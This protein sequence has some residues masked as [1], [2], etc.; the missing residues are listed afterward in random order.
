MTQ[1]PIRSVVVHRMSLAD[2]D[3]IEVYLAHPI[4][5]WLTTTEIGQW[6]TDNTQQE[7]VWH[8]SINSKNYSFDIAIVAA[9][10]EPAAVEFHLRFGVI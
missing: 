3:D 6:V 5:I 9:L 8:S 7:L 2:C 1:H 4:W 10:S